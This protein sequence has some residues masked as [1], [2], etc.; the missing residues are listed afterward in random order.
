MDHSKADCAHRL[1]SCPCQIRVVRPSW[2]LLST[3]NVV[4]DVAKCLSMHCVYLIEVNGYRMGHIFQ[5][6]WVYYGNK[7][8]SGTLNMTSN[9]EK[10]A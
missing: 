7:T 9:G 4:T 2:H 8:L 5:K 6:G 10:A 3:E 1:P